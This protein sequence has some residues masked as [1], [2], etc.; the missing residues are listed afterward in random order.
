M[1]LAGKVSTLKS[2]LSTKA[3]SSDVSA[4]QPLIG[5]V[6]TLETQ[7]SSKAASRDITALDERV[8]SLESSPIAGSVNTL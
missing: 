4:L 5:K 2:Q 8:S 7:I 6:S 1:A 3:D